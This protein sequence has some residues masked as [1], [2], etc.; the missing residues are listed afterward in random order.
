MRRFRINNFGVTD[1]LVRVIAGGVYP[2]GALLNHSCAPNC[3][4]RY[5]FSLRSS[6]P[7]M[8]VVAAQDVPLGHELTHSYVE[9]V[10][11][12]NS[13]LT[14]LKEIFGFECQ[15][16]RCCLTNNIGD[17]SLEYKL[18]IKGNYDSSTTRFQIWL[19][20]NY[21]LLSPMDL[22][23]W[24]LQNY[25]FSISNESKQSQKNA[26]LHHKVSNGFP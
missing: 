14:N 2:L 21:S 8:E 7:V 10:S 19:P 12:K 20:K 4:L 17:R 24:I 16:D 26:M 18:G 22:V 1:S 5:N 25:N 11:S 15:C 3:L 13:R 23:R 6:S 9:L